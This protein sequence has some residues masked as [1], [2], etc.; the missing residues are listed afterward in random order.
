MSLEVGNSSEPVKCL[1][2][3]AQSD[4]R[5]FM[6]RFGV[7]IFFLL[8]LSTLAVGS[9]F[10]A[11]KKD[12]KSGEDTG[13]TAFQIVSAAPQSAWR[14]VDTDNLLMMDLPSGEV[15]IEMRPDLAPQH[16]ER[17]KTLTR[18]GFYNGLK[19]HRVIEGFMAQGGD[20]KGDGTGGSPLPDL[21]GEFVHDASAIQPFSLIGRDRIA[22]RIGFSKGLPIAAEPASLRSI[23]ADRRVLAWP[24]HCPGV[25]SM[26][27]ATNPNSANSQFFLMIGDARS[28]LDQ[29]YT[30]W[31]LIVDGVENS[32]RISR[33]EPPKRPT[34]II[35]MQMVSDMPVSDRPNIEVLSTSS[36]IFTR[37]LKRA[38]L[39]NENGLV[40]DLCNIRAPRR[41]NGKV[42]L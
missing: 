42:E 33:G 28:S 34:P 3:D 31:G 19:F 41:I 39:I 5:F 29:R 12:K 1:K 7:R 8:M 20:P 18:Q 36:D 17:I 6:A 11:A 26:A 15:F 23:R 16:V 35:R 32:R 25:M 38:E 40:K 30:V 37:Y 10:A 2:A 14:T 24:A 22:S 9:A 21:P 4:P 13:P 27:R